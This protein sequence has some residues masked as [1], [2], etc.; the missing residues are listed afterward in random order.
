MHPTAVLIVW[1]AAVLA[2]QH[3]GYAGLG[4][5]SALL[6][7]GGHAL[8]GVWWRYLWRSRWLLLALWLVLAYHTPGDAWLDQAWAPT[9]EGM[10]EAS[11][12][13]FRLAVMLGAL[14]WLFGQLGRDGLVQALW[15]LFRPLAG[16]GG[17]VERMVVRLSLVFSYL[18]RRA[19]SVNW[20]QILTGSLPAPADG[21]TV[22]ALHLPAWRWRDGAVAL[23]AV[24]GFCGVLL[25]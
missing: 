3:L 7:I 23:A 21:T 1:L 9:L 10:H 11:L 18:D 5:L 17:G 22:I 6:A 15:G 16:E 20:R 12:Q 19:N 4:V 14:A 8:A 24:A 13:A 25:S 2:T